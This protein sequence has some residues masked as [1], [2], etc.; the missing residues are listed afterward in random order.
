MA[1]ADRNPG[2]FPVGL[3]L[4][5]PCLYLVVPL[6][7]I[8]V[9]VVFGLMLLAGMVQIVVE[10]GKWVVKNWQVVS[11]YGAIMVMIIGCLRMDRME[12]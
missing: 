10:S 3:L 2:L 7:G 8:L 4:S 11:A 6:M 12:K 9:N 1:L 5:I